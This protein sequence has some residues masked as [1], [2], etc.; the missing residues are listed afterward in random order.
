MLPL[1]P[2][3]FST[4]MLCPSAAPSLSDKIRATTSPVPPAE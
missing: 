2:A 3:R 4:T 1:A